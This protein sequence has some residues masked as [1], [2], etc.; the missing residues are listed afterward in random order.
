MK[1]KS[2]WLSF[3]A[4]ALMAAQLVKAADEKP[5]APQQSTVIAPVSDFSQVQM[6]VLDSYNG[7]GF[8]DRKTGTLYVYDYSLSKLI[9]AKKL[10]T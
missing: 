4:C 2:A 10:K 3:A 9:L 6:I 1:R 7:I 8:F 5:S